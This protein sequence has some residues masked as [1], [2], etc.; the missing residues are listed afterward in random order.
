MSIE[1]N[2]TKRASALHDATASRSTSTLAAL[3][4]REAGYQAYLEHNAD[5]QLEQLVTYL[6]EA[7]GGSGAQG[8]TFIAVL[9]GLVS[10]MFGVPFLTG[11]W[12][13]PSFLG[14]SV[15]L[16]TVMVFDIGVY[17]VVLGSISGMALTLGTTCS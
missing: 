4:G 16:S 9:S 8:G 2:G 15:D 11:L 12:T 7:T 6:V 14:V 10:L 1:G 3:R 17:F 13:S 5:D